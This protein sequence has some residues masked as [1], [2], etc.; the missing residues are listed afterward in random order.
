MSL[1]QILKDAASVI[2]KHLSWFRASVN[3]EVDCFTHIET[4]KSDVSG[5]GK[6]DFPEPQG[7]ELEPAFQRW[8]DLVHGPA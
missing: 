7:L 4:E 6:P 1:K 3:F 8:L 5:E 2:K